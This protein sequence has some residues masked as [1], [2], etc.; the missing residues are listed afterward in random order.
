MALA[1]TLTD[2]VSWFKC[3][4][5]AVPFAE[6]ITLLVF[7]VFLTA[8]KIYSW[9]EALTP[10]LFAAT[11]TSFV[12]YGLGMLNY[13]VPVLCVILLAFSVVLLSNRNDVSAM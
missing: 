5:T 10:S 2:A 4:Q 11:I 8:L 6:G 1:C 3:A 12:F 13:L 9:R 7:V